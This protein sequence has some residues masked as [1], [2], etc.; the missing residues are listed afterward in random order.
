MSQMS[1]WFQYRMSADWIG[2]RVAGSRFTF[3]FRVSYSGSPAEFLPRNGWSRL[4]KFHQF[5]LAN[6]PDKCPFPCDMPWISPWILALNWTL[7]H[8]NPHWNIISQ[9]LQLVEKL[10]SIARGYGGPSSH[11]SGQLGLEAQY[12]ENCK[13]RIDARIFQLGL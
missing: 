10:E 5:L 3:Q 4:S 2:L 12:L 8:R 7:F 11:L 6:F 1:I 9:L 13:W